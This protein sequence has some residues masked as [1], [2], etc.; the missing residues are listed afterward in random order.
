VGDE[1][2]V[3]RITEELEFAEGM[4]DFLEHHALIPG[5]V[6]RLASVG[7]DGSIIVEI[8]G[9]SVALGQFTR[10]RLLVTR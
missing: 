9:H 3:V 7:P 1:F 4:L 2:T 5:A 10:D 8:D 6:G